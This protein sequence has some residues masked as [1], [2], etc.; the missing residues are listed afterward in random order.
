MRLGRKIFTTELEKLFERNIQCALAAEGQ[1]MFRS[2]SYGQIDASFQPIP[3]LS[4]VGC[5]VKGKLF[6]K[7]DICGPA[8]VCFPECND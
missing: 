6:G 2:R 5:H 4:V 7:A 8:L 3:Q 1:S